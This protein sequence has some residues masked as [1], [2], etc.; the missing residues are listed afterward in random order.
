MKAKK[1]IGYESIA[2]MDD[3]IVVVGVVA[4]TPAEQIPKLKCFLNELP[5]TRLIYLKV[6]GGHLRIVAEGEG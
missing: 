6:S 3:T 1:R 5:S 4:H 2:Q